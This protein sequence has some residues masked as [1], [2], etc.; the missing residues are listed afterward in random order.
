MTKSDKESSEQKLLKAIFGNVEPSEPPAS[1]EAKAELR[2][3]V[4]QILA[5]MTPEERELIK[6]RYGI[7][8]DYPQALEETGRIFR[9]TRA[10]VREIEAKALRKLQHP[11]RAR[12]LDGFLDSFDDDDSSE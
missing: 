4:Q 12:K 7:G 2:A 10:R 6:E 11:V 9:V 3:R 5:N 1:K 8:G